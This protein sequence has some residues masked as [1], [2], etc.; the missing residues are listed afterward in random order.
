MN[1]D[2]AKTLYDTHY[3]NIMSFEDYEN[4]IEKGM[5]LLKKSSEIG[6]NNFDSL[7]K[8]EDQRAVNIALE[9]NEAVILQKLLQF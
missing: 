2:V 8:S 7:Y 3:K 6:K 1:S 4:L 5:N 9:Y